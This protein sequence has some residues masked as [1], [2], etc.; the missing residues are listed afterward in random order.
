MKNMKTKIEVEIENI[1]VLTDDGT[2]RR[3][4][5]YFDYTIWINGKKKIG[6]EDGTWSSQTA[7]AFRGALKRGYAAQL[8]IQKYF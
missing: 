2:K 5:Y 8:V 6:S 4:F 1:R 3:G 7:G